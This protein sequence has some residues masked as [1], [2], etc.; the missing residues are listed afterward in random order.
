MTALLEKAL[1]RA[2][3][4]PAEQQ[5]FVASIILEKLDGSEIPEPTREEQEMQQALELLRQR[6]PELADLIG[7]LTDVE[8]ELPPDLPLPSAKVW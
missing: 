3:R 7:S 5:D 6:K 1:A 8:F 2:A 4:L